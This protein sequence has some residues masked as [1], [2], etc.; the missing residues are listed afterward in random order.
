MAGDGDP[1]SGVFGAFPYAFRASESRLFRSYAVLGGLMALLLALLFG[2]A[3]V[4]LI[5]Q[6]SGGGG[7]FTFSRAFLVTVGFAVVAPLVAPVL[8]VARRHRR[9][10]S[11]PRYDAALAA[12][13][14]LFVGALY[15]A[16][17]VST[18]AAQQE[19]VTGP[20]APVVTALYGLP[21]L[22]SVPILVVATALVALAHWRFR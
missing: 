12:A 21:R 22:A 3:L 20:L 16:V 10:D 14:Y 17:V 4:A 19:S 5:A 11:D 15:L 1:Y 13:G 2:G 8:L 7:T 9:A 6:T 18:P